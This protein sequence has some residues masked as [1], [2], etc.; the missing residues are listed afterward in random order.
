MIWG[1][2]LKALNFAWRHGF[3]SRMD[4]RDENPHLGH[5]KEINYV[6]YLFNIN[7]FLHPINAGFSA[8]CLLNYYCRGKKRGNSGQGLV[9]T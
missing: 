2:S 9:N 7:Y 8:S 6:G 3:K 1:E 5:Y 4:I